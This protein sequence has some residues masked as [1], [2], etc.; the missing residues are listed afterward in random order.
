MEYLP[1]TLHFTVNLCSK[2]VQKR[3]NAAGLNHRQQP[4]GCR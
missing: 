1:M 4:P 3:L 2:Q